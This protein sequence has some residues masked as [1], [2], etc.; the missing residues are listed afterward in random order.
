MT[1]AAAAQKG[2]HGRMVQRIV[3]VGGGRTY[4]RDAVGVTKDRFLR[5][6]MKH[7]SVTADH[8]QQV[9][10]GYNA[11]PSS[12]L[13][14][15]AID[16]SMLALADCVF[17]AEFERFPMQDDFQLN[18][19]YHKICRGLEYN[20]HYYDKPLQRLRWDEAGKPYV[21]CEASPG[22]VEEVRNVEVRKGN[23]WVFGLALI[24]AVV[25]GPILAA[26]IARNVSQDPASAIYVFGVIWILSFAG[27]LASTRPR[28]V[29][30]RNA[31]LTCGRCD[32]VLD[33]KRPG[34]G[35]PACGVLFES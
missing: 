7:G 10:K 3:A 30:R 23:A 35:C 19:R 4:D 24:V 25:G 21:R 20:R 14:I 5:D 15:A 31:V 9:V 26:L 33:P 8:V 12:Y 16:Q 6:L 17:L 2:V 1:T 32:Q 11:A 18:G 27:L 34:I 28:R 13:W 22:A 29:R